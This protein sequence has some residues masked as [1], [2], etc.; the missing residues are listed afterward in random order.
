MAH[1]LKFLH[2]EEAV[3]VIENYISLVIS[4]KSLRNKIFYLVENLCCDENS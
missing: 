2:E 4:C 1:C 3:F